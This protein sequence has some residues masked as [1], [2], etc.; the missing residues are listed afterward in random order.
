MKNHAFSRIGISV[1]CFTLFFTGNSIAQDL[2]GNR[3]ENKVS[4]YTLPDPL[5]LSNGK[6]VTTAAMWWNAEMG[7][8]TIYF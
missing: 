8:G 5:V 7:P 3:E 2:K 1:L 6:K 4:P